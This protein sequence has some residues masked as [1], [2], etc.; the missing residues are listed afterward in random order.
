MNFFT[1]IEAINQRIDIEHPSNA[2]ILAI[3]EACRWA[4]VNTLWLT[5]G[6]RESEPACEPKAHS[7]FFGN[8]GTDRIRKAVEAYA[9]SY[10]GSF[11]FAVS[12]KDAIAEHGKLTSPQAAGM[13]NTMIANAKRAAKRTGDL[14][15]ELERAA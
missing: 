13:L 14:P 15:V 11:E 1:E 9:R 8:Y 10:R 2:D 6:T 3:A 4:S 12:M 7:H 5:D